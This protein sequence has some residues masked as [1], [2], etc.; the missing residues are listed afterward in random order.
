MPEDILSQSMPMRQRAVM[1]KAANAAIS[2]MIAQGAAEDI[3]IMVLAAMRALAIIMSKHEWSRDPNTVKMMQDF[4]PMYVK[5]EI[6]D[7]RGSGLI[8]EPF[9]RL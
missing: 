9:R 5:A 6:E 4:L 7:G 2:G 8:V 1:Y 3:R